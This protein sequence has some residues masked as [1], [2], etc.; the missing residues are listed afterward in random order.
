M[1]VGLRLHAQRRIA[2]AKLGRVVF[3]KRNFGVKI[4]VLGLIG[5]AEAAGA[6]HV[7]NLIVAVEQSARR[8]HHATFHESPLVTL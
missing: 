3:L 4:D 2:L 7:Y 5:D 8:Q 1:T 6:Y